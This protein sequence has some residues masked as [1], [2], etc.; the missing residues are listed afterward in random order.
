MVRDVLSAASQLRAIARCLDGVAPTMI[1][2]IE[3]KASAA[4]DATAEGGLALCPPDT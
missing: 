4:A 2:D 1:A 3:L